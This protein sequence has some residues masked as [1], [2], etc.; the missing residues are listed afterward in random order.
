MKIVHVKNDNSKCTY[1]NYITPE[2]DNLQTHDTTV[3]EKLTFQN[4]TNVIIIRYLKIILKHI[5]Q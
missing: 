5:K 1:C 2:K 3:H 4:I